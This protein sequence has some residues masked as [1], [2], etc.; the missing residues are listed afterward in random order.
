VP[1]ATFLAEV[2]QRFVNDIRPYIV[3]IELVYRLTGRGIGNFALPRMIFPVV[4]A[5]A[6][7][8]YRERQGTERPPVRLLRALGF[9][10][11]NLVWEMYRHTLMHND[12]M[13]CATYRGRTVVWRIGFNTGHSWQSGQLQIDGLQLY[14]DFLAFLDREASR[15]RSRRTN[16]WVGESFR[17]NTGFGRATL[18]EARRLGRR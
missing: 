10:F 14:N 2:R 17:F 3:A 6:T 7:V 12:E 4:E 8:I 16:V 5:V 13:A 15:P 18:D 11:P 9:E 1:K